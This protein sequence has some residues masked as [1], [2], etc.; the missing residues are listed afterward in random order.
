MSSDGTSQ[1]PNAAA[2]PPGWYADPAGGGGKR[3]WDGGRWTE[4]TREP[5]AP[6]PV[7]IIGSYTPAP[8]SET[9]REFGSVRPIQYAEVGTAYT[10]TSWWLASSP[11]WVIVPQVVVVVIIGSLAPLSVPVLTAG[12]AGLNLLVLAVLVRLAFADRTALQGGGNESTASPWWTLLTP[13]AYLI[14]RAQ[15]V[16]LY[17]TGGWASVI[18][19]V[20]AAVFSPGVAVLGYFAVLGILPV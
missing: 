6:S 4:N 12:I 9:N 1:P 10:R 13:L 7:S 16:R 20:I 18:W 14:A 8:G 19:W 3:W 2:I 15:H 11:L 5:E 17:A